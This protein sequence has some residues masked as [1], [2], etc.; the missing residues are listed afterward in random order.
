MKLWAEYYKQ[1]EIELD[2][3]TL[4]QRV[5]K[6]STEDLQGWIKNLWYR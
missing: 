3:L 4:T 6:D 2:I 1:M 5:Y